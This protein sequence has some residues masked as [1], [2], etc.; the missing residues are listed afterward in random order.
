MNMIISSKNGK[1]P[2]VHQKMREKT[3]AKRG[4]SN[5][6]ECCSPRSSQNW[7]V[8]SNISLFSSLFGEM[9]QLDQY[10]SK[11]L[12][13]PTRIVEDVHFL[14]IVSCPKCLNIQWPPSHW[15]FWGPKPPFYTGSGPLPLK[16]PLIQAFEVNKAAKSKTASRIA[17]TTWGYRQSQ[18]GGTKGNKR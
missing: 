15:L 13:P 11:G 9:I 17:R 3:L 8:V 10:F 14:I 4:D 2:L 16:G 6:V 18:E 12:K 1:K 7:L 5:G